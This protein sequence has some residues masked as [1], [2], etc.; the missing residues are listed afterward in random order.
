M[1]AADQDRLEHASHK[2]QVGIFLELCRKAI[3]AAESRQSSRWLAAGA[4]YKASTTGELDQD[5]LV[6][7][8]SDAAYELV[9]VLQELEG[10]SRRSWS[11]LATLVDRYGD[12]LYR[13]LTDGDRAAFAQL[14]QA[15][16]GPGTTFTIRGLNL[17]YARLSWLNDNFLS[18]ENCNLSGA[19]FTE[20]SAFP[21]AFRQCDLRK[22]S[23][24][25]FEG[26]VVAED[27]D[28]TGIRSRRT[29][30]WPRPAT[31]QPSVFQN[32]RLDPGF[33]VYARAQ[34]VEFDLSPKVER[35]AFGPRR[36]TPR[37]TV[38]GQALPAKPSSWH[39][40]LTCTDVDQAMAFWMRHFKPATDP[41][42]A[43][44]MCR[45]LAEITQNPSFFHWY[46]GETSSAKFRDII[47]LLVEI[48]SRH[49]TPE[50][51]ATKITHLG[52][53]LALATRDQ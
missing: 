33:A 6:C 31:N 22:A 9:D 43:R 40:A 24:S 20:L 53:L 21:L 52:H 15:A 23:F 37:D 46:E 28:L 34:G 41:R 4:I 50:W 32:C 30:L 36:K 27:C 29:N 11:E 13:A 10:D 35:Y 16:G 5:V 1:F 18:F 12:P 14:R 7:Q 25:G 39:D 3:A 26:T 45:E 51:T 19:D 8:I 38:R 42:A 17:R 2:A 44:Q 48:E 49:E 47:N